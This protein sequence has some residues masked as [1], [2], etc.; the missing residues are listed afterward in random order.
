MFTS[1][2]EVPFYV[3]NAREFDRGY[4]RG[5]PARIQVEAKVRGSGLSG[6]PFAQYCK[7]T[8]SKLKPRWGLELVAAFLTLLIVHGAEVQG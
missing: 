6:L 7:C 3:K 1:R 2:L 8:G 5:S 4:P